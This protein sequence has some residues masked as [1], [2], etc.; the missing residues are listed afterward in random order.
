VQFRNS[1]LFCYGDRSMHFSPGGGSDLRSLAAQLQ[2]E[3]HAEP[4]LPTP[5]HTFRGMG[6]YNPDLGGTPCEALALTYLARDQGHFTGEELTELT[7]AFQI[8]IG[9]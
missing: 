1:A 3:L 7:V 5:T 8:A 6:F 2:I 9:E 4:R